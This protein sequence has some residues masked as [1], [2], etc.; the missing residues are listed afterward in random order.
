MEAKPINKRI[1]KVTKNLAIMSKGGSGRIRRKRTNQDKYFNCQRMGHF[2]RD[3]T[4]ADMRPPRK[5]TNKTLSHQQLKQNQAN[6]ATANNEDSDLK[7][8]RPGMANMARKA[9]DL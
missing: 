7:P 3:C 4:Y 1:T 8:F 2:G 6:I 5:K 9:A